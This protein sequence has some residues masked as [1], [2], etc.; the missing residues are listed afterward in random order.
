MDV[1]AHDHLAELRGGVAQHLLERRVRLD[2]AAVA[3]RAAGSRSR[4]PRTA[5]GT[6]PAPRPD[7]DAP[8]TRRRGS[9]PPTARRRASRASARCSSFS[10]FVS[11]RLITLSV[12][13]TSPP[14]N[15]GTQMSDVSPTAARSS[16]L[17]RGSF[18]ASS[19]SSGSP[20]SIAYLATE[21]CE[22][23]ARVE[24]RL[25]DPAHRPGVEHVAV[26]QVDHRTVR[27]G[28]RLRTLRDEL[29]DRLQVASGPADLALRLEDQRKAIGAIGSRVRHA[30]CGWIDQIA[31]AL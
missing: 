9:R 31:R 15:R 12:P 22:R 25:C 30:V 27:A 2:G 17:T 18:G 1:V 6:G 16:W 10:R 28:D 8:R 23:P 14:R 11:D 19:I 20:L 3:V 26:D 24:H 7:R 21:L 13:I 4:R 5:S 29:H